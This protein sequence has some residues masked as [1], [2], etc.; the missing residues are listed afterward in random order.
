M[1]ADVPRMTWFANL[2]MPLWGFVDNHPG[3]NMTSMRSGRLH[4]AD[5]MRAHD[6]R[7]AKT[8]SLNGD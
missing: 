5:R 3:E 8:F 7:D 4:G 2:K 1:L 6:R